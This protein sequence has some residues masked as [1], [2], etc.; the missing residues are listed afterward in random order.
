MKYQVSWG[1]DTQAAPLTCQLIQ[2]AAWPLVQERDACL[3]AC[4]EVRAG[5]AAAKQQDDRNERGG[6][7][8]V[9]LG[10]RIYV[11]HYLVLASTQDL[12]VRQNMVACEIY[13][14]LIYYK[15]FQN[16]NSFLSTFM[17]ASQE[18]HSINSY[19]R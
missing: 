15:S 11:C 19:K 17:T 9:D 14:R 4:L 2:G 8:G 18:A 5:S 3:P 12:N 7:G 16:V 1:N 13:G 6:G 10:L